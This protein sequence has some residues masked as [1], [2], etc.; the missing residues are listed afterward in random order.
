VFTARYELRHDTDTFRLTGF[1]SVKDDC[2]EVWFSIYV[3]LDR[4]QR[5]V[6]PLICVQLFAPIY[7]FCSTNLK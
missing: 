6:N 1:K 2:C 4:M 7:E 3:N 5:G